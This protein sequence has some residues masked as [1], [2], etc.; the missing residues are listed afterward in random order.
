MR[1]FDFEVAI[2]GGGS[3]G[4]AAAR[5]AAAAGLRTV[6]L[7]GGEEVGGLCILRGCMPSKALLYAAEVRH[8]ASKG[9]TWGLRIPKVGFDFPAV[10]ARKTLMIDDF[11][12]YRRQQLASGKFEFLRARARFQDDHT[13]ALEPWPPPARHRIPKT[14]TAA[15][16]VIATGSVT[17]PVTLPG[18]AETGF[19]TSDDILTLKQPP[20][21]L[22]VLGGGPVALELAQFLARFDTQVTVIQRSDH[23]LSSSDADAALALEQALGREGLKLFTGTKLRRVFRRG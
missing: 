20:R 17:A 22:I 8:L 14:L 16:F 5:T 19:L 12:G 23:L 3:A 21:S 6:V 13:L 9:A 1:R 15:H 4:Y 18:L 10:M 2:L 7:E 11:A